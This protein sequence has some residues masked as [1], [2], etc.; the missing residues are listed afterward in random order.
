[1]QSG[2]QIKMWNETPG[3]CV[4]SVCGSERCVQTL[5][6][7]IGSCVTSKLCLDFKMIGVTQSVLSDKD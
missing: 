3:W 4:A 6:Q 2:V 1:M 5:F 7:Q